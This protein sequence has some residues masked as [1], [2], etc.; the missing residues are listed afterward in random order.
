MS[1]HVASGHR[2]S[3]AS[4]HRSARLAAFT[5]VVAALALTAAACSSSSS[6]QAATTTTSKT[7]TTSNTT[8]PVAGSKTKTPIRHV[9]VVMLENKSYDAT[10]GKDSKAPYL[11]KTLAAK[12]TLLT[13]YYGVAHVSL[14]NYIA[15]ISGQAPNKDTA[16][17]CAAYVDFAATGPL[18]ADGQLPGQGCVFPASLKT[19][20]GQL[21]AKGLSWKGYLEDMGKDATRD[22]GTTCAHP[23]L[24]GPDGAFVASPTDQYATRHNPFVYFHSIIDDQTS[25]DAHVVALDQ[26]TNDLAKPT[27][28]PN[29]AMVAPNLCNDGHDATCAGTNAAGGKDGGLVGI[30]AWTKEW[31]PKI[32]DSPTYKGGDTL[33]VVTFDEADISEASACCNEKPGPNAPTPGLSGPGGGRIGA[34]LLSPHVAAG[35][36]VDTEHNHYSMLRTIED[37]FGVPHLGYAGAKGLEPI[38]KGV[39]DAH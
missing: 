17:D 9:I 15:L 24:G 26:L 19:L 39:L 12:G 27:S 33:V 6:P 25:C 20:P 37:L 4:H 18:D 5:I 32:L 31:M 7:S 30:D 23:K 29:F 16:V 38:A 21:T 14:G 8:P 28:A 10:W 36:K 3:P 22:G 11:S 35:A 2:S 1:H 34:L 13:N